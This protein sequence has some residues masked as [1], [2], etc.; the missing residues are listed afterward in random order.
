[1]KTQISKVWIL[2]LVTLGLAAVTAQAGTPYPRDSRHPDPRVGPQYP[3]NTGHPRHG[4][5]GAPGPYYWPAPPVMY[6]GGPPPRPAMCWP[7]VPPPPPPV[8]VLPPPPPPVVYMP[9]PPPPVYCWP[10]RPGFSIL[11]NF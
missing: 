3:Q 8:M 5:Y 4:G 2:S 6:W 7:Q 10:A 11:L 1:M 9:P